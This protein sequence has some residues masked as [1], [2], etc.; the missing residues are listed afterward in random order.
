MDAY[1]P[2]NSKKTVIYVIVGVL[3]L[4]VIGIIIFIVNSDDEEDPDAPEP[5]PAPASG[6]T[7]EDVRAIVAE[8]NSQLSA[9]DIAT[10]VA[11]GN[12]G[13]NGMST[14][15]LAD[16]LA[17]NNASNL[18][19]ILQ[20]IEERSDTPNNVSGGVNRCKD[21]KQY[22]D[23][24]ECEDIKNDSE[25][26]EKC[27]KRWVN[28]VSKERA[29][30]CKWENGNCVTG[31]DCESDTDPGYETESSDG[32]DKDP[33]DDDISCSNLD[34]D[35]KYD[36]VDKCSE[37]NDNETE[38]KQK[39]KCGEKGRWVQDDNGNVEVCKWTKNEGCTKRDSLECGDGGGGGGDIDE[40]KCQLLR[41]QLIDALKEVNI[42]S[43]TIG[44]VKGQEKCT[45]VGRAEKCEQEIE[46]NRKFIRDE[47]NG[48][49]SDMNDELDK[50]TCGDESNGTLAIVGLIKKFNKRFIEEQ[51]ASD[52]NDYD[53]TFTNR[54]IKFS[55]ISWPFE[56]VESLE[57]LQ[58]VLEDSEAFKNYEPYHNG[59]PR[60]SRKVPKPYDEH[61]VN[62]RSY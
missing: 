5:A 14:E 4:S 55:D 42:S 35:K 31:S 17:E 27:G 1:D 60:S 21:I 32:S 13:S 48:I 49:I 51:V 50:E 10:I 15:D 18:E 47:L 37:I 61:F 62:F 56:D 8:N 24:D 16:L 30:L 44:D 57:D 54:K 28:S 29:V 11:A 45:G 23:A 22:K 2:G 53:Y 40:D 6:L 33:W 41:Y 52:I 9:T 26:E 34:N 39:K 3:I 43:S 12:S 36:S 38:E 20:I 59:N 7:A 58:N 46:R 19:Q 25:A